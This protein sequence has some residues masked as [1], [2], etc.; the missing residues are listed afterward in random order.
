MTDFNTTDVISPFLVTVGPKTVARRE[1]EEV[2][3]D[4][5]NCRAL[6]IKKCGRNLIG[7][8]SR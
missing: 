8:S 1:V 2:S 4:V 6:E 5:R 7:T 3:K